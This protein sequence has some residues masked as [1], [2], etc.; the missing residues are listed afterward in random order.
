MKIRSILTHLLAFTLTGSLL[1][2]HEGVDLGPN[3]GRILEFSKNETMH[4]EVVLKGDNFH[5]ALLDKNMKPV[6]MKSQSLTATTG[7]RSKAMRLVVAS[8]AKGFIVPVIKPGDWLILQ[9]KDSASAKAITALFKYDTA[10]CG[11]CNKAEW[12]CACKPEK[13]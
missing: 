7:E 8:D 13:P 5:I 10:N 12:L 9:Y 1:L 2:A 6:A 4:G 11:G 3:G